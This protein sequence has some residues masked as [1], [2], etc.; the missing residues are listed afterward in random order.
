MDNGILILADPKGNAWDFAKEVYEK[1][2]SNPARDRK[3]SLGEVEVNKFNDGEL[4]VRVLT[5]VRGKTCFF[6]H[7]SS[8]NAQDWTIALAEVNDALMRSSAGE[9]NNVL[10]YMKYSRQDRMTGPRTPIS[11]SVVAGIIS[12]GANRIIN[13]DLHNPASTCAYGIPFDNLKAY[14][15]IVGHLMNKYPDFLRNLAI[16]APDVGSAERAKSYA[17]R[18]GGSVAI[19]DKSRERAG[20]T[21]KMTIIGDVEGKNVLLVDDMIDTAGT[22]CK[23]AGILKEKGALKVWAAATHGLFS[24]DAVEKLG[25]SCL[26]KVIVTDS[27]PQKDLDRIEVVSL[28][29][30]FAETIYRIS[31]GQSVS[32]LFR[33]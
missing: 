4:F 23:A 10:P 17:K 11:A 2:N 25:K 12:L 8:M 16:V 28:T 32:E 26:D 27:I 9:V 22:L 31:H 33:N 29:G 15:V 6:I 7:D 19:V 14:P 5:N 21:G 20:V 30:L 1:L 3:Y 18:L 24:N 13:T